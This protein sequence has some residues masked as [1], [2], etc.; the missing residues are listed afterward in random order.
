MG[1]II[2]RI[3][4]HASFRL[5]WDGL[6]DLLFPRSC[7]FC[8]QSRKGAGPCLCVACRESLHFIEPPHCERCGYP[9]E[10]DYEVPAGNF[11]CGRCRVEPPAFDRAR[12][13]AIYE[14]AFKGL[15]RFYKYQ[16]Q[17]GALDEI[18]PLLEKY[19][20]GELQNYTGFTVVPV[21][22]HVDKLRERQFDQACL[23][24]REVSNLLGVPIDPA[25]LKRVRPTPSQT[26]KTR[27]ERMENVRGAFAVRNPEEIAGRSLLIVD[28]VMTTGATVN[29]VAK[30]LK[31]AG[32]DRVEVFTLARAA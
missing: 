14:S 28:D 3:E 9:A 12:S 13:V 8:G 17:T 5:F 32:A 4:K 25:V 22:L 23:L 21:P 31:R 29:E 1:T 11:I 26:R 27:N 20:A 6:R 18:R 15:V 24:A 30:V 2:P 7:V 16:G 19:F 10:I